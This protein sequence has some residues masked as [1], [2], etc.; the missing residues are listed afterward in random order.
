[1]PSPWVHP[2]GRVPPQSF[3][4]LTE[5]R[6]KNIPLAVEEL[7]KGVKNLK[8]DAI[9]AIDAH[10]IFD[11]LAVDDPLVYLDPHGHM[12]RAGTRRMLDVTI[13][14]LKATPVPQRK[15]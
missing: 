4:S 2:S 14:I 5:E 11:D 7:S 8:Q 9:A 12:G 15:P 3:P 6:R 10:G 13:E 1:M